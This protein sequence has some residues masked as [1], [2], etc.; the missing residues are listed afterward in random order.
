[1]INKIIA[2]QREDLWKIF[3]EIE[4]IKKAYNREMVKTCSII[5]AKSGKCSED[6]AFCAQ[7]KHHHTG[8]E[9]F[10]LISPEKIF[11]KAVE[12]EHCNSQR[13]SIVTSGTAITS[14]EDKRKILKAVELITEKTNLKCCASLGI[15]EKDFML[16]LKKAG[17]SGYH[18]NLETARSFFKNICSTHNYDDDIK[19]VQMAKEMDFYVCSGGIFG[20]G[21]SWEHRIEMALTLK[22]LNVDSI[23][24]NFLNPIKG[25]KLENQKALTPIECLK[26]IALYRYLHFDK[27]IRICGGREVNLKQFQPLIF[28]A[29]ANGIMI[30]NYLTTKGRDIS[31]DIEM[32][33]DL[34]LFLDSNE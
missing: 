24:I 12:M 29:G 30:G 5:N 34:N 4:K 33:S 6:C 20:L 2:A 28:P 11:K 13:F 19:T 21:E 31:D 23:A 22:E 27:D 32:L 17:L 9:I 15:I 7:S 14:S 26:I 25:T 8:V 18:H 1:M 3:H 10:P 16:D